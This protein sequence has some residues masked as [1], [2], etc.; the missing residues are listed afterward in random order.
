M[1]LLLGSVQS[2]VLGWPIILEH[3]AVSSKFD[4]FTLLHICSNNKQVALP[5]DRT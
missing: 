5:F 3:A 2:Y 4:E 1:F